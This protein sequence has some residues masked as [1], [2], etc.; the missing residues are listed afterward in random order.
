MRR[1][2]PAKSPKITR[3]AG[4]GR[5]RG[6]EE[7]ALRRRADQ[8]IGASTDVIAFG[9]IECTAALLGVHLGLPTETA[10]RGRVLLPDLVEP[11][12]S[13]RLQRQPGAERDRSF[14]VLVAR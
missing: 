13:V 11:V 1:G 10:V 8:M 3:V 2:Y 7:G 12:H 9:E 6:S 14:A 5:E 4:A